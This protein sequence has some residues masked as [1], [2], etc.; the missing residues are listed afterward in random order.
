MLGLNQTGSTLPVTSSLYSTVN[1]LSSS[2]YPLSGNAY[3]S[4]SLA[5]PPFGEEKI[6]RYVTTFVTQSIPSAN[7]SQSF[8]T[9]P[10][11]QLTGEIYKRLYHN[12]AY[13]LK[14]RGTERGVKALITAFGIPT[15]ILDPHEYGGY[16]IYQLQYL[17][18][19]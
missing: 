6:N 4:S 5:L 10:A 3:L 15:D 7:I 1:I 2:L 13:L 18:Q 14:T 16:N 8:A 19:S 12:L 9:L 11:E 17:F